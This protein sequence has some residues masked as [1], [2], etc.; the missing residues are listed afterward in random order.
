MIIKT[1]AALTEAVLAE[2]KRLHPYQLPALAGAADRRRQRRILRLDRKRD[3][4]RGRAMS[5]RY[6]LAIDQGTTSTRAIL[7]DARARPCATAQLP[8]TQI[9]PAPGEVEHD[10]EEIWRSVLQAGRAALAEVRRRRGCRDRHHQSARDD[11]GVGAGRPASRSPMP[12]SGRTAAPPRFAPSSRAKAGALTSPRSPGSSSIPISRR[13]SLP[14][15]CATCRGW[16]RGRSRGEVCFGTVDSFLLFKPH[17]RQ[18]A[19]DR[20]DQRR[21]HHALRHQVGGLG[22]AAARS[23]CRS[24]RRA[25]RDPRQPERLR[26]DL[27]RAFRRGAADQGRCRRSAGCRLRS[28]LLQARHAQ[29]DLRHWLLRARQYRRGEGRL[30]HAHAVD[31]LLSAQGQAHLC[32]RGRDLHGRRHGAMA[33][34]QSRPVRLGGRERGAR[35]ARP[36]RTRAS[37]SFR[38]SRALARRSGMPARAARCLA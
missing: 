15:C 35:R 29:G 9:Y 10:P 38:P 13:P 33:A 22:R 37:I 32:A 3:G 19:R 14:G 11:G 24:A 36:T 18:A 25:A 34:R 2:T 7:F 17:R 5:E 27:A 12:S 4:R 8:I 21:A 20:R 6:V 16:R 31:D 1:R 26:R 23:A 28:G 30:G